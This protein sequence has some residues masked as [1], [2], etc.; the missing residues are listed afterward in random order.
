MIF[1]YRKWNDFC[2][3][4]KERSIL[5]IPA[6]EVTKDLD[7]YLVLKH[8]VETNVK[9]ALK[10]AKIEHKYGHRGS[11]YVQA[12]LMNDDGNIEMLKE[13]QS[14]GHEI[15]YHYDV[16]DSSKGDIEKAKLEFQKNKKIFEENGFNLSTVC[17]HGNPLIERVG[18]TSNR[19]FFRN[20]SVRMLYPDLSDIMVNFKSDR[21]TDY[22]YYSDAGRKFKLIYDPLFNDVVNS[23]DKN[24]PYNNLVNLGKVIDKE[25][26]YII[27]TH[28]HRWCSSAIIYEL[29]NIVFKIIKVI[30]RLLYKIPFMKKFMGKYY[31]LAKKI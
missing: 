16:M 29:K 15:S 10:M 24:I 6:K 5:S 8:D 20:E 11:Y 9:K 27:S 31:Y 21:E 14:M 23:N 7:S 19:D 12:Y 30:A 25:G 4:L 28:P 18:Y 13:M 17:Q 22:L 3:K 1:V 26:R 2:K